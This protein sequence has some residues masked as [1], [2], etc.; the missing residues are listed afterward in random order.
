MVVEGSGCRSRPAG[1]IVPD[2][3][4]AHHTV[5]TDCTDHIS[6]SSVFHSRYS[7]DLGVEDSRSRMRLAGLERTRSRQGFV[8]GMDRL[9]LVSSWTLAKAEGVRV[10][11]DRLAVEAARSSWG[12]SSERL[13]QARRG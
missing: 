4:L 5:V 1:C 12:S 7:L 10:C 8:G 9:D 2:L 6:A 11:Y 13:A 3:V